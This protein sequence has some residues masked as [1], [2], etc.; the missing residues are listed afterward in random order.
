MKSLIIGLMGLVIL[1]GCNSVAPMTPSPV[2]SATAGAP[3]IITDDHY[4]APTFSTWYDSTWKTVTS[5]SFDEAH[6]YFISPDEDAVILIAPNTHPTDDIYPPAIPT[7]T[8]LNRQVIELSDGLSIYLITTDDLAEHYA[9]LWR[10]MA[11]RV[12]ITE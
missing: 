8:P 11:E 12:S 2:L 3:V 4:H 10:L 7:D 9:K 5:A 1:A 6:V